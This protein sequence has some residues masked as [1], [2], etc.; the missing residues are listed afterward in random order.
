[1]SVAI[2]RVEKSITAAEARYVLNEFDAGSY[3]KSILGLLLCR[4]EK[5]NRCSPALRLPWLRSLR[6]QIETFGT[7]GF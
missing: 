4:P 6:L 7:L 5:A 2:A 3:G 1:V